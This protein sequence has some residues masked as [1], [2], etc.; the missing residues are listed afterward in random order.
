MEKY[1]VPKYFE[2]FQVL[3]GFFGVRLTID[4]V[5]VIM[6]LLGSICVSFWPFVINFQTS[7]TLPIFIREYLQD[8]IRGNGNNQG[9]EYFVA[10]FYVS[11]R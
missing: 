8:V 10:F 6:H 7:L 2:T 3:D 11:G 5:K 4:N 9:L 1:L